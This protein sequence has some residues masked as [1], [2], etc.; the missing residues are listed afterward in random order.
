MPTL[1]RI[2][3]SARIIDS[4]SRSLTDELQA[5]WQ[6]THLGRVVQLRDLAKESIGPIENDTE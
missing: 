6:A 4:R 1:L 2:N 5:Q 3:A